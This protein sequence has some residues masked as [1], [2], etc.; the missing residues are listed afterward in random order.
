M[1][2]AIFAVAK[3]SQKYW[4]ERHNCPDPEDD[5]LDANFVHDNVCVDAGRIGLV[6]DCIQCIGY[7]SNANNQKDIQVKIKSA[8]YVSADFFIQSKWR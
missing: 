4:R 2:S 8:E 7:C 1:D 6:L 5:A 3:N